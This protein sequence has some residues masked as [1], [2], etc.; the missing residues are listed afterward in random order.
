MKLHECDQGSETWKRLRCGIP[1]ASE[2]DRLVT[3]LW[4][5]KSG[6]GPRGYLLEKVAEKVMG[7]APDT[8]AS[9][10]M[11]QGVIL[12]NEAIPFYEGVFGVKIQ[13]V[14]FCTTDD[15]R[16]GCSPDGLVG[17]DNGLEVKCPEPHTHLEY[18]LGDAVPKEYAAQVQGSMFV[19][20]RPKWTFISYNRFFPPLIVHVNRDPVAQATIGA[21]LAG[22]LTEFD[23]ASAK[24]AGMLRKAGRAA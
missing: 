19:T 14:G 15:G 24:I 3:P 5:V 21:A 2:F 20:G 10:A 12:E 22:F 7:Y 6:D 17:D 16:I 23:A 4:K 1:T 8:G 18:L 9:F 13:K 11:G